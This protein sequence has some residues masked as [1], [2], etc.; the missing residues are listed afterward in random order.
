[1][2]DGGERHPRR[3]VLELVLGL[4]AGDS[5]GLVGV[6][7]RVCRAA[8]A[9]LRLSGAAVT[10][11]TG[12]DS[13]AVSAASSWTARRLEEQ[14]FGLGEG[15]TRDA[16]TARRPVVEGDLEAAGWRRWPGFSPV[17][18][19]AG[20]GAVGALPLQVGVVIFGVLTLYFPKSRPLSGDD[21]DRGLEFAEFTTDLLVN[22]AVNERE[23][24][25]LDIP[26][27]MDLDGHIYQAQGMVM[28]DLGV[29]L[30]EA[31]ARMRAYAYATDQDLT[32]LAAD[33]V[34]G[35]TSIPPDG[36][37]DKK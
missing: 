4:P 23:D 7:D 14:Q 10:L 1:V 19:G 3:S 5:R 32:S 6:L 11:M 35:R 33:I 21:V 13:Q 36:H 26:G 2:L 25:E 8:E 15:P 22:N 12:A 16:H 24:L 20:V 17:A 27:A 29:G 34:A 37:H 28:V 9:D 18:S 30:T 31:L